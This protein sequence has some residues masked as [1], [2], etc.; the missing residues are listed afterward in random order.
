[1]HSQGVP[2]RASHRG[3]TSTRLATSLFLEEHARISIYSPDGQRVS[4]G[5]LT[6]G[7]MF[8]E[9]A[10]IDG[11]TP[12]GKRRVHG[13]VLVAFMPRGIFMQALRHHPA[14]AEAVMKRLTLLVRQLMS[15]AFEFGTLVVRERVLFELL[16]VAEAARHGNG[17]LILSP[18]PTHEEIASR[19]STHREAVTKELSRLERLGL[20]AKDGRALRIKDLTLL[21][22]LS[23]QILR[24]L[25]R[26][27]PARRIS[28]LPLR[29]VKNLLLFAEHSGQ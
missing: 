14:F 17:E 12:L 19:I 23:R 6:G 15:R 26:K 20:I 3:A 5:E 7:E 11:V 21:R 16:R 4:F 2:L 9:I 13:R 8:G 10:A 18:A 22:N 28:S 29:L 25:A 27:V 1:M 24:P